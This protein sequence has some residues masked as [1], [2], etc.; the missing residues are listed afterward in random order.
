MASLCNDMRKYKVPRRQPEGSATSIA[1]W[2][3]CVLNLAVGTWF[4]YGFTS[5]ILMAQASRGWISQL[6]EIRDSRM[7]RC[8][9]WR[10]SKCNCLP[11]IRY[12]YVVEGQ[13]YENDELRAGVAPGSMCYPEVAG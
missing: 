2:V 11:L 4:T 6:G 1:V 8:D 3:V 5:R 13:E 7:N 10:R 12:G 9:E